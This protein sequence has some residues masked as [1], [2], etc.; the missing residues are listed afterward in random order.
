MLKDLQPVF[1]VFKKFY[2]I[3]IN[4]KTMSETKVSP[5][6]VITGKV[7]FSYANVFKPK[8]AEGSEEEKYSVCLLIPKSDKVTMKAINAAIE[9]AKEDGKAK[10][11]GKIPAN[12]K[13]P[14]RDGDTER[15]DDDNYAGHW[16]INAS[17]KGKPGVLDKNKN[18]LESEDDFYSGCYG[19]ASVNFY[20]FATKGNKGI[21][22]G[23]NNLLKLEDGDRLS[24]R[25]NAEDDFAD[26][27]DGDGNDFM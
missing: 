17:A 27:L 2:S 3:I 20:A 7:R 14:V 25:S 8:K 26:D 5:T 16:F 1:Q 13:L 10:F 18:K 19:K 22:C 6:R 21:A 15:D 9:A 23:L 11:G 4:L 12:L 24:G